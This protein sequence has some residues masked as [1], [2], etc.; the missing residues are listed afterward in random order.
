[1]ADKKDLY[2]RAQ[3]GRLISKQGFYGLVTAIFESAE[4][5]A[6]L[7]RVLNNQNI[8]TPSWKRNGFKSRHDALKKIVKNIR[9]QFGGSKYILMN[10]YFNEIK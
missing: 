4:S 3:N 8:S 7:L 1:M 9:S 10:G 2:I 5:A 6:N